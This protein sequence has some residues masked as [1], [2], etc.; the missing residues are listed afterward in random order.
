MKQSALFDAEPVVSEV[1]D[2]DAQEPDFKK[3][4]FSFGPKVLV[5]AGHRESRARQ[6]IGRWLKDGHQPLDVLTALQSAKDANAVDP[7]SYARSIMPSG[8]DGGEAFIN[9][10]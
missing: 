10:E 8:P 5:A 7:V 2:F 6:I 4:L 9:G 1:S 3:Q